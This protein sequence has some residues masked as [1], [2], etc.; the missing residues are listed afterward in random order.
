VAIKCPNCQSENTPDSHFCKN[1]AAPLAT[2]DEITVPPI[3]LT[4]TLQPPTK[5]S[6][7][8]TLFAG[9]YLIVKEVG[10]GGMGVVYEAEQQNPKRPVALKVIRGGVFVDE[11]RIKMFQ[12]EA[13]TLARLKHPNIAGIYESGCT[14]DGRHFFAMEL[15]RGE[16]L[17]EHL[18]NTGKGE[19]LSQ[20]QIKSRLQLFRK[21]CDAVSYA[22]QRG[23]IHRDL[24]P[25]NILVP[26]SSSGSGPDL[27]SV[28]EIK[29]LDFGLARMTDIDVAVSTMVT[30]VGQIYGTFPYM[31]PEQVR[32]NPDEIDMRTDVYSLGVILYEMLTGQLPYEI[33][34]TS[35]HEAARVISEEPPRPLAKTWIGARKPD[36]DIQTVISKALEKEPSRRYQSVTA[37][38][39]DVERYL[40]NQPILA[41]PPSAIYQLRKM[42]ARHKIGFAFAA[43][44]LVLLAAFA[45]TM[46]I[47]SARIAKERTRAEKEA[48]KANAINEFLLE[49]LGSANPIEGSRRDVTVLEA[50]KTAT[51]KIEKAF[52]GQPQVEAEV[53]QIVGVTFLRLGHYEEAEKLMRS[54]LKIMEETFGP[55]YP[56]LAALLNSLGVLRQERGD[57]EEAESFYRRALAIKRKELGDENEDVLNIRSNLALLLQEKGM[58]EEAEKLFREILATDRK[59]LGREHLNVAADLNNLGNLLL[60]EGKY[61][62]SEQLLREAMAILKKNNHPW[63]SINMGNL[64]ELLYKKGEDGAAEPIF[65]EALSIGLKDFGDKNQDVAK[66]RGKYGACLIKLKKYEMAEEQLLAA[67]PILENSLGQQNEATQKVIRLLVDLYEAWGKEDKAGQYRSL[68]SAPKQ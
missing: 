27:R 14:D 42:I 31:S 52:A 6:V 8:G 58:M 68:L 15:V 1:C 53:R 35:L 67:L 54:A 24:K 21:I 37:L 59:L 19:L 62:E 55:N 10:K 64:A 12:R 5:G 63:L 49:T 65:A 22:H 36:S 60:K 66:L 34:Q 43:G 17:N 56:D 41:R 2:D 40:Q 20:E 28:P 45:V 47:L 9:R 57:Y 18:Q 7:Q 13:Q 44:L 29:I 23:V 48:A 38:S 3:S 39:D 51:E 46:T 26:H 30:E 25:S 61:T 50:L 33:K 32:G 16:T 4:A 11:S